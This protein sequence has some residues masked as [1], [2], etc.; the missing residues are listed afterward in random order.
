MPNLTLAIRTLAKTPFVTAV[1]AGSL[2][3]GIGANTAIFSMFERVLLQPLAVPEPDRLVNLSAPGPKWGSQ[4]CSGAGGC[5]V[6]LSYPMYRDLERAQQVLTG[7]AAHRGFGANIAIGGQAAQATEGL[8]VS[9][10]YFPVIGMKPALGRL[11]GPADDQSIGGQFAVVLSHAYWLSRLGSDPGVL[12]QTMSING[13]AFTVIGVAPAGFSGTTLGYRPDLFIPISMRGAVERGQ[14]AFEN[15]RSYWIYAFGRLKDGVSLE[16]AKANL[17]G[18]YHPI[19]TDVEAPLQEGMNAE[20]LAQFRAKTLELESGRRGQSQVG[21]DAATPML[22]LFVVTAIVLLIAC[23]NVANLLLARA[24]TRAREMAVR[25]SLGAG[26]GQLVAQLL[27]ES[28]LLAALAGGLSL[29]VAQVT[30]RFVTSFLPPEVA[31]GLTFSL[32]GPALG[33]A[34]LLSLG[35]GLLFGLAPAIQSTRPELISVIKA[36]GVRAGGTRGGARFRTGMVTAQVALSMALLSSAAL[37]LRSLVNVSAVELGLTIDHLV[38]FSVAP[39][40]SGYSSGKTRTLFRRMEEELAAIPGVTGVSASM[41]PILAGSNWNTDVAVEGF[42]AD[43]KTDSNASLN[44]VGVGF[45]QTVGLPVLAGREFTAAD[46]AGSSKVVMVN[47]AFAKRFNMGRDVVGKRMSDGGSKSTDL[48]LEI[49]GLVKDAKYS[50][51][52]RVVPPQFFLPYRQDTTLGSLSFYVRTGA[53]SAPVIKAIPALMTK[54]DPNLPVSAL[55]TVP[56]QV[57]ETLFL[58]R[59]ITVFSTAFALL[60]TILAAVGLYGVLAYLVAQRTREIGVRMALG[61]DAPAVRGMVLRQVAKM[62]VTGGIIGIA[63]AIAVGQAAKSLLFGLKGHDPLAMSLATI[64]LG[65]VTFAAGYLPA[66]KASLVDPMV[67]LRSD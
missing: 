37:F 59:M 5:E 19:V 12:N 29:F 30:L 1:A 56:Q 36:D 2:A 22:L 32:S 15:R 9:G 54:I 39:E 55:K 38:T 58:D 53:A 63:G 11:F 7:L 4:S 46:D 41:V 64:V 8:L 43:D 28:V 44:Y 31:S 20:V 16:Q 6:V 35:T 21:R 14:G 52:K 13:Q 57:K 24:A 61:A 18:I 3:L 26:R 67:A 34:A 10:S 42:K 49:I 48:N 45:F 62:A 25:L 27:T 40:L 33:F 17:N 47:E 23:I 50:D 60:A 66:R 65:L 51:V